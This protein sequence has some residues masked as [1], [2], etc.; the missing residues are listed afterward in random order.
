MKGPQSFLQQM[1]TDDDEDDHDGLNRREGQRLQRVRQV[2]LL[3]G[4]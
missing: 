1:G 3:D 2:P 4:E